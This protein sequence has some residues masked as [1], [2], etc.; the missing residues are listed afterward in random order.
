MGRRRALPAVTSARRDELDAEAWA[1]L[2][3]AATA[4]FTRMKG[5][6]PTG[7]AQPGHMGFLHALNEAQGPLTPT[8]LAGCVGVTPATVTGAITAL[9]EAGLLTRTRDD[10]D[11]RAVRVAITPKGREVSRRWGESIR[12][13]LREV[14][15]P[16]D[17]EEVARVA[18]ILAR[19]APP[20]RGPPRDLMA[21][22][23]HDLPPPAKKP[24]RSRRKP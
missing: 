11:R 15:A 19:V 21:A 23:R 7:G 22:L 4:M 20:V 14:F 9:E 10:E 2:K 13:H 5:L 12:A 18:E 17:D 24:A 3:G 16:L 6:A 8:E 1:A